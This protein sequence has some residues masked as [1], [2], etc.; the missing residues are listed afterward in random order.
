MDRFDRQRRLFGDDGQ[1]ALRRARVVILGT[2]GLGSHVIQQLGY[3]GVGTLYPVDDD[4][5]DPTNGN[6][7]VGA[8][9]DDLPG[10]P[11]VDIMVRMVDEIDPRIRVMP[12]EAR[13]RSVESSAV[14]DQAD[15][16]F[17]CV[18]ND[19]ARLL[20]N[21]ACA[22]RGL[23]YIDVGTEIYTGVGRPELG[24]R[25]VVATGAEGCLFCR[26]L[27]DQEDIRRSLASSAERQDQD[28]IYGVAAAV[29][30]DS[31]PAVVSL[32]GILASLAVTEF[33][34]AVTGVRRPVPHI[35]YR[36][37]LG[38]VTR[39]AD[40]PDDCIYCSLRRAA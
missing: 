10:M 1:T 28:E 27:L 12:V 17:G 40:A 7:L 2:G 6:R 13:F 20:L 30:G 5:F 15:W 14:L 23:G 24:G 33:M 9:H 21:E 16:V 36:G 11:K 25:L 34:M 19:G 29:I 31:G 22:Q 18:D 35:E 32:N 8:R 39:S 37:S 4:S 26:G 3:L 38:I